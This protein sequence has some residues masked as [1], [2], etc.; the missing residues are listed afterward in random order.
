MGTLVLDAQRVDTKREHSVRFLSVHGPE[1]RDTRGDSDG[2]C[3]RGFHAG[4]STCTRGRAGT[5]GYA[6]CCRSKSP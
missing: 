4:V 2:E 6:S 5:K 3:S 1:V